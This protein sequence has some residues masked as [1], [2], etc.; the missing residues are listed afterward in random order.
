MG[1]RVSSQVPYPS[2]AIGDFLGEVGTLLQTKVYNKFKHVIIGSFNKAVLYLEQLNNDPNVTSE[3]G[4]YKD[5]PMMI[6]TPNLEEPVPQTD[7]L[8]N[9]PETHPY[10]ASWNR[11]PIK[12]VDGSMLT[13]TTRRMQGNID[14]RIFVDS[15][16]E[17]HDIQ[18]SFLNFFRGLN[19]VVPLNNITLEFCLSDKIKMLTDK[20][21]EIVLDLLD[22]NI[23]HK[24]VKATNQ[25]EYMI[26][27]SAVP[28][29]RLTSLSDASTFYGGTDFAEFALS[30]SLQYE[31][32]IPSVLTLQAD[33]DIRHIEFNI[34][35]TVDTDTGIINEPVSTIT[36]DSEEA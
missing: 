3:H 18:M 16:P 32:E 19:T 36:Q 11:P 23:S 20:N 27:I 28:L 26:P 14:I 2:K 4:M 12:F 7:F 24:L 34:R 5:L 22:S 33:V 25:Y 31:L 9:Y 8:W 10:M 35:S 17:E 1:K 13:M 30:G 6:Y 29:L 21:D 15:Q